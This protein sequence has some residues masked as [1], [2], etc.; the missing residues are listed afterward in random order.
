MVAVSYEYRKL[1][2]YKKRRERGSNLPA[3][4]VLYK[5]VLV[6]Y[7]MSGGEAL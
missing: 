2:C 6:F 3:G 7:G 5:Y 1:C 4:I